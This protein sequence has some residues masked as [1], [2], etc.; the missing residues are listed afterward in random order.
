[1][2]PVE[3][4]QYRHRIGSRC[5]CSVLTVAFQSVRTNGAHDFV[6]KR[7]DDGE[8]TPRSQ[9][10][11]DIGSWMEPFGSHLTRATIDDAPPGE[12]TIGRQEVS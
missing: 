7:L 11:N 10:Q 12:R 3:C 9:I 8:R 4:S 5:G 6:S 2:S 1:M